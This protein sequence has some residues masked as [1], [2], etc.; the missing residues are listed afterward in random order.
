[1]RGLDE[2]QYKKLPTKKEFTHY[3]KHSGLSNNDIIVG[4]DNWMRFIKDFYEEIF[5]YATETESGIY[6]PKLGYFFNWL[7]P[8]RM[9][10]RISRHS[11]IGDMHMYNFHTKNRMYIPT[12]LPVTT[13]SY[14]G[15]DKTFSG[16]YKQAIFKKIKKGFK[17]KTYFHTL[18]K[19]KKIF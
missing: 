6:V 18:K 17:Y 13:I 12:F 16:A 1:M 2:K 3:R 15:M 8:K 7:C 5:K 19:A 11:D 14:Y 9:V 10:P 4:R